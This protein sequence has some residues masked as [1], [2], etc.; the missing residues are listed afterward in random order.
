MNSSAPLGMN[1]PCYYNRLWL[2]LSPKHILVTGGA[3]YIGSQTTQVLLDR[4]YDV[5][6]VD[7]LS[8]G[9]RRNVAPER[10]HVMNISDTGGLARLMEEK[11]VAAVIHFAGYISVGESTVKPE[12]YFENN[13]SG[14]LSLFT[15]MLQAGVKR[16]VFSSTA[17]VYGMPASSPITEEF[18]FAPST[19][20]A[21]RR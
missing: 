3:G 10:L 16:L 6:V 7:D 14:S 11:Q 5:T 20:M 15:A 19:L 9:Y 17:A 12:L 18:P 21:S 8:R 4:G 1:L 2:P 13:V